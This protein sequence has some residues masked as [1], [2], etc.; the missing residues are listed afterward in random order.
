MQENIGFFGKIIKSIINVDFYRDIK[1]HSFS[2]GF[3]YLLLFAA[4]V[5]ITLSVYYSF[6]LIKAVNF[7]ADNISTLPEITITNGEVTSPVQQP[8]IKEEAKNFAFILDTTG[9]ITT[10]A[11]EYKSGILVMKNKVII[12][13][14]ETE[15]RE[16]GLSKIKNFILNKD[17][18]DKFRKV[19]RLVIFP[20]VL[21]FSYIYFIIAKLLQILIFSLVTLIV[22]S[23]NQAKIAYSGLLNIATCALTLPTILAVIAIISGLKIPAFWLIYLLIYLSYLIFMTTASKENIAPEIL[24]PTP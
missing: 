10:I 8:F 19:S 20:A 23:L 11:A 14:D 17:T 24:P 2:F 1:S 18:V 4:L 3:K 16:Y 12:K 7:M 13:N 21:I 5:T 9:K 6:V 15:S 22:N